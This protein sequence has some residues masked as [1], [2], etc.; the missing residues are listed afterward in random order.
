MWIYNGKEF[1]EE[2]IGDNY[3]FVYLITNRATNKKYIGKK[4]FWSQRTLPPLKG[5][6]RKR[7]KKV[8]S[9]WM[10]YY[11][12]NEELKLLVEKQGSD[13]YYRQILHLCKTK[14][15]CSYYEAKLQFENDVLLRDDYYNEFIGCKIHSSHVR[16]LKDDYT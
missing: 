13:F 1:T 14:G 4:F 5:K 8:M 10:D 6:T 12:S 3:G 9:D 15:E 11:G 16:N 2:Q 7:K